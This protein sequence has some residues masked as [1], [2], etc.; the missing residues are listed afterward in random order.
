[1]NQLVLRIVNHSKENGHKN[2]DVDD[3]KHYEEDRV[4]SGFVI[5]WHHN[6]FD[7]KYHIKKVKKSKITFVKVIII[8]GLFDVVTRMYSSQK[9]SLRLLK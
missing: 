7:K 8:P 3:N 5:S 2:V 1:M 4:Q 9:D 6:V